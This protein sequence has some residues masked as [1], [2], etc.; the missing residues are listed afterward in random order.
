MM[1]IV[2]DDGMN[3]WERGAAS[4]AQLRWAWSWGFALA[5][6]T[7]RHRHVTS[8]PGASPRMW[9]WRVPEAD[10]LGICAEVDTLKLAVE[11]DG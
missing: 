9:R 7:P 3:G 11:R 1:V 8:R 2:G 4:S 5:R 10:D 6:R